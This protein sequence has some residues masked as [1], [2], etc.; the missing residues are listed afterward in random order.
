[1]AC[2]GLS[3]IGLGHAVPDQTQ[4]T[5][6]NDG[7]Q[8]CCEQLLEQVRG[9][10]AGVI[11]SFERTNQTRE[12]DPREHL[13]HALHKRR[14]RDAASLF[15]QGRRQAGLELRQYDHIDDIEAGEH[16]PGK[17]RT[18]IQ[19][20]LRYARSGAVNNQHDRWRNKNAQRTCRC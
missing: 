1:M 6:H 18:G 15:R 4:Q 8:Q 3:G 9:R 16:Q 11:F 19:L 17:E 2:I 5:Q 10:D 13:R 12:C 7:G 20:H 14:K